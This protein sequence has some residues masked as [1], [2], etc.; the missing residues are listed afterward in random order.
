M[1]GYF[2]D[3]WKVAPKLTLNLGIRYEIYTQPIDVRDRGGLFDPRTGQIQLP[4][5]NGYSRAIV[6]GD[7]NN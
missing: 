6:R 4:G 1:G 7:H 2:Q 3:D 5:Q